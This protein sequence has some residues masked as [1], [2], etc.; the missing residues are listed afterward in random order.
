M[1]INPVSSMNIKS[2]RQS[3][4]GTKEELAKDGGKIIKNGVEKVIE[5]SKDIIPEPPKKKGFWAKFFEGVGNSVKDADDYGPGG[6]FDVSSGF[7]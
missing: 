7:W 5:R 1:F 2:N 6:P 3:F 4:T